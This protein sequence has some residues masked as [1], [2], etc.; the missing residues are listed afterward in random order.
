MQNDKVEKEM[1]ASLREMAADLTRQPH[2]LLEKQ[3]EIL[4]RDKKK[5]L[6]ENIHLLSQI[7]NLTRDG[8]KMNAELK[9][10]RRLLWGWTSGQIFGEDRKLVVLLSD[11]HVLELRHDADGISFCTLLHPTYF[12]DEQFLPRLFSSPRQKSASSSSPPPTSP[13]Q[14]PAQEQTRPPN[15]PTWTQPSA[16]FLAETTARPKTLLRVSI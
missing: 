4:T 13:S 16:T 2:V 6:S 1:Q 8:T 12:L 5:L 7:E 14:I 9:K 11:L 15:R 10:L 3:C